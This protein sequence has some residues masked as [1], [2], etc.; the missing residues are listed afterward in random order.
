[1]TLYKLLK[2]SGFR[3]LF[4]LL[5]RLSVVFVIYQITRLIFFAYNKHHFSEVG[6]SELL[7]MMWGGF[8]FDLTAILYLNSLFILLSL[9]P[10][11]S[12]NTKAYQKVL[13]FV[14]LIVNAIGYAFNTLDIFYFDFILKRSTFDVFMFTNE[15]NIG[16]L[17]GQFLKDYW[18]GFVLWAILVYGS[19]R[20]YKTIKVKA[21]KVN[22]LPFYVISSFI[23]LMVAYFSIIGIRG[24]FTRTT[25]PITLNNAGVY[26]KN[27]LELAIVL[28]TPFAII[29]TAT[30]QSFKP[31]NY[32][33]ESELNAIYSPFKHFETAR[34][35]TNQNVVII[36]VESLAR[37]YIGSLNKGALNGA[38][39][40]Y[41][42]FLDSLIGK[43][44]TF[45]NAYANGRKSIDALPSIIA[46]IPSL[47]QPYILSPYATNSING[48][49]N[50]LEEKGYQTAF[51]H[52]APNGSMGFD[53]FMNMSGHKEYYGYDEY[54]NSDDFDGSWG[55]WDEEFL[56]FT[57][58]KLRTFKEPFLASIFTISSHHPF[59]IPKKY[60]NTF[61][62]GSLPIH[63][64]V[65][66]TDYALKQF[67]KKASQMPWF[68][69]SIFIITA[70][71]CNQT[72][73]PEY[74][75]SLGAFAVPIIF[76][77]PSQSALAKI[78]STV[79]QQ[80]D[81]LPLLLRKLNYSG[82]F[83][84]FGSDS[85]NDSIPFAVNYINQTWQLITD[86]YFLQ[87]RAGKSV[88]LY[89]YK[90]DKLLKNNLLLKEPETIKRLEKFLKA[91][92]QQYYNRLI[93]NKMTVLP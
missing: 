20:Y 41:T 62:E 72:I 51:F 6:V 80:I 55:I 24:G 67:F 84:S 79:T 89:L 10:L 93:E 70:D 30:K 69:N 52:G 40:G 86:P 85:Q 19:Y 23:F 37:E 92:I 74:Q 47:V 82:D 13:F 87:Y 66:Y 16:L 31:K 5:K 91:Y 57:A 59:K 11:K 9:I 71:H 32:Y 56:G 65:Q 64:S 26:T 8:R 76:Y 4:V 38:Y 25:R 77:Q 73:L 88:G 46:S 34:A 22:T 58:D 17:F 68:D 75:N 29:K 43:S 53:A 61:K 44:H 1:M 50:I 15:Q 21:S 60:H 3:N 14:F 12:R 27:P 42:P 28:N 2:E 49:G 54:A 90:T 48:I 35:F 33:S 39:R 18:P 7:Y 36:I 83:V 63:K 81:I 78:D 45:S